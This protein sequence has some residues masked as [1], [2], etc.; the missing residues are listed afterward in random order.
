MFYTEV[1]WFKCQSGDDHRLIE[2]NYDFRV[3]H[4]QTATCHPFRPK[5]FVLSNSG[6]LSQ[7]TKSQLKQLNNKCQDNGQLLQ[8]Q[9]HL[10]IWFSNLKD[11]GVYLAYVKYVNKNKEPKVTQIRFFLEV[12]G[13]FT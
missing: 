4:V 1:N 9:H 12:Q 7:E 13:R 10:I 3:E 2:I 11:S 6:H 8:I 5:P